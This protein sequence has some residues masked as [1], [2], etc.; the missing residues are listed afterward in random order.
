MAFT[1]IPYCLTSSD[2]VWVKL[3]I[4]P[5]DAAY[6]PNPGKKCLAAEELMLMIFPYRFRIMAGRTAFVQKKVPLRLM[7]IWLSH[8]SFDVSTTGTDL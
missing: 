6:A 4:P 3:T 7:E 2:S 8:S 5:F 1:L